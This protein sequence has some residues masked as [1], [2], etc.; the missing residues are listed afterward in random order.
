VTT[1]YTSERSTTDQP[2]SV[3]NMFA[4]LWNMFLVALYCGSG[5]PIPLLFLNSF[6]LGFLKPIVNGG[7][8][9]DRD[10]GNM[11]RVTYSGPTK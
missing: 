10:S 11:V 3:S 8:A 1:R 9:T 7:Y 4:L 5:N 2:R 6:V